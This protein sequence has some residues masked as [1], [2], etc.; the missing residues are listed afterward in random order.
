MAEPLC[1][2]ESLGSQSP[3]TDQQKELVS[4]GKDAGK[5][6]TPPLPFCRRP[7]LGGDQNCRENEPAEAERVRADKWARLTRRCE[8]DVSRCKRSVPCPHAIPRPAPVSPAHCRLHLLLYPHA[9][10]REEAVKTESRK[11]KTGHP[12]SPLS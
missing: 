3:V 5:T 8:C 1:W 7:S 10:L 9:L 2:K 6:N 4:V 12:A 11:P